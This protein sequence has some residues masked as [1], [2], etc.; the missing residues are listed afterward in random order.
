M[1]ATYYGILIDIARKH[2]YA[3]AL[4]GSLS[5]DMD[6]IAV[7]WTDTAS[8]HKK[9]LKDICDAVG[10]GGFT[11]GEEKPHGRVGYAIDTGAGGYLDISFVLRDVDR[12]EPNGN[13]HKRMEEER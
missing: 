11:V 3:L 2:G 9:V 13:A 5:R 4:H 6:L 1:Y 10:A 7:P 12:F 8:D